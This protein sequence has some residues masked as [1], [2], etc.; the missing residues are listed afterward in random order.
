ME[1]EQFAELIKLLGETGGNGLGDSLPYIG[2]ILVIFFSYMT[3][4]EKKMENWFGQIS[5]LLTD[6]IEK[7]ATLAREDSAERDKLFLN[8]IDKLTNGSE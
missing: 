4:Q 2:T 8:L 1:A 5:T 3:R 6:A 7:Q